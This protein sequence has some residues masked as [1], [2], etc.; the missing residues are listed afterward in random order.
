MSVPGGLIAAGG[1]P[2]HDVLNK[3]MNI[4]DTGTNIAAISSSLLSDGMLASCTATGGGLSAGIVYQRY[5][6]TWIPVS[7]T[8]HDHS[9][10][11]NPHGGR[12]L[13]IL[14]AGNNKEL[15]DLSH[16]SVHTGTLFEGGAWAGGG[17]VSDFIDTDINDVYCKVTSG[18]TSGGSAQAAYFTKYYSFGDNFL[19][20]FY[21]GV[22]DGSHLVVR[23]GCNIENASDPATTVGSTLGIE[24]CDSLGNQKNYDFVST[25]N[26]TRVP[27]S[28]SSS[29]AAVQV[30]N[31]IAFRGYRIEH[32]PS[33]PVS[34]LYIDNILVSTKTTN[35]PSGTDDGFSVNVSITTNNPTEKWIR[36][37][38]VRTIG[39]MDSFW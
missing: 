2:S 32:Y 20:L 12:L 9:V 27:V 21:L 26:G 25:T 37:K 38:S 28:V 11:D 15:F 3:K 14:L 23:V 39:I 10:D 7:L 22:T 4:I 24:A 17:M 29:L 33:I 13:N 16:M 36:Y 30:D 6:N 5:S 19:S 31:S 18:P 8:T 34:R 35:V 1:F